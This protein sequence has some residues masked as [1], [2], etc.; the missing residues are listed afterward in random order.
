MVTF[1]CSDAEHLPASDSIATLVGICHI[2]TR[3]LLELERVLFEK[4]NSCFALVRKWCSFL[5]CFFLYYFVRWIAGQHYIDPNLLGHL[6]C[7]RYLKNIVKKMS[8]FFPIRHYTYTQLWT[9]ESVSHYLDSPP[10][11]MLRIQ[12]ETVVIWRRDNLNV[13]NPRF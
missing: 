12:L 9:Y 4:K 6:P 1:I 8:I 11:T 5:M 7:F 10:E 13:P 3:I 2:K